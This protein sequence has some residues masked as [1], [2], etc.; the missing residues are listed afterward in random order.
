MPSYQITQEE[1]ENLEK[2][3]CCAVLVRLF[4]PVSNVKPGETMSVHDGK[5]YT[6]NVV[7]VSIYPQPKLHSGVAHELYVI[8]VEKP[9]PREEDRFARIYLD[10]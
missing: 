2:Y 6:K 7:V 3:G 8:A 5:S 1:R 4:T 9:K 10:R